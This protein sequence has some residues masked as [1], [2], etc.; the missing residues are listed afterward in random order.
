M[1][2]LFLGK[3]FVAK[4]GIT[5]PPVINYLII[6]SEVALFIPHANKHL[7]F[8]LWFIPIFV[9]YFVLKSVIWGM[10]LISS[11]ITY[12]TCLEIY[13]LVVS[14]LAYIEEGRINVKKIKIC[15]YFIVTLE[16]VLAI[17][18]YLSPTVMDMCVVESYIWKGK[19]VGL[20]DDDLAKLGFNAFVI[21]TL[22]KPAAY[23]N[24]MSILLCIVVIDI[25]DEAR[26]SKSKLIILL[27]GII[28]LFLTGIRTPF[29]ILGLM[30]VILIY[31]RKKELFG[32]AAVFLALFVV[33]FLRFNIVDETS[34]IF[35]MQEGLAAMASGD[36]DKMSGQTIAYSLF[37]IPYFIQN[38]IFGISLGTEY[39]I[40]FLDLEDFSS[41]DVQFMYIL[42]E[43][44]IVGFF[45]FILPLIK[46]FKLPQYKQLYHFVFPVLLMCFL[47]TILDDTLFTYEAKITCTL[48]YIIFY[49][50]NHS[51]GLCKKINHGKKS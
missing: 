12:S 16:V 18:Q 11:I 10:P 31:K 35:R 26:I 21:G 36:S 7:G 6:L 14:A 37:M 40:G 32:W 49:Y 13:L 51:A 17:M 27:L 20:V 5:A 15:F 38:P 43:V 33:Y 47:L 48:A 22:L 44:G 23:A 4:T 45:L 28:S 25:L 41:T 29:I 3:F 8:L 42:C 50:K 9:T 34:S 46:L 24:I 39:R 1:L 30:I 19:E 2:I